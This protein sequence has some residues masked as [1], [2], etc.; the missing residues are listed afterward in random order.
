[1]TNILEVKVLESLPSESIE[2]EKFSVNIN[3]IIPQIIAY[4]LCDRA[5][6]KEARRKGF[7]AVYHQGGTIRKG[8][9]SRNSRD[10]FLYLI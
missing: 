10:Y 3:P 9:L 1:M 4:W 6:V 8:L 7:N 5:A 2:R